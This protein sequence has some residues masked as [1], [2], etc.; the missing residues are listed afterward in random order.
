M[1]SHYAFLLLPNKHKCVDS[2]LVSYY[3]DTGILTSNSGWYGMVYFLFSTTWGGMVSQGPKFLC[4][5]H[6]TLI[7]PPAVKDPSW[8]SRPK[9]EKSWELSINNQQLS[10]FDKWN[11]NTPTPCIALFNRQITAI[12]VPYR[13]SYHMGI[14]GN[15]VMSV[16]RRYHLP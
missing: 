9:G 14:Q 16:N 15:H 12:P 5:L 10:T 11:R 3:M 8:I 6:S 13:I 1:F 4:Q 7:S 2:I